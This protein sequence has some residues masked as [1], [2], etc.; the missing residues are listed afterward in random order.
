MLSVRYFALDSLLIICLSV[1]VV[2]SLSLPCSHL[3]DAFLDRYYPPPPPQ[4][5]SA[6]PDENGWHL[7][8]ESEHFTFY[9]QSGQRIPDWA[10]ELNE[11]T[12]AKVARL[13]PVT[14]VT[15]VKYY[16][17]RSQADLQRVF[18][19]PRKGYADQTDEGGAVHSVYSCHP[20]EVI[21]VLTYPIG[22]PPAL[23]EEGVA[24]AYDWR[25]AVEEGDVHAL[26]RG[27]LMRQKL[28]PLPSILTTRD[29]QV[30]DST[31]AYVVAGSFVKYLVDT[32]GPDKMRSLFT[33]PRYSDVQ[34]I[35]TA[36]QAIYGQSLSEMESEWQAFLRAWRPPERPSWEEKRSLLLFG[37]SSLILLLLGGI[38]F[39][40]VVDGVFG[41]LSAVIVGLREGK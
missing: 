37:G 2:V 19:R 22:R 18:G 33:V 9:T 30:H 27:K 41:R 38:A 29:F 16:K 11:I 13:L 17:Y 35:E 40:S 12:Y 26:A 25:F 15:K 23:F 31:A 1:I 10:V 24:V 20:H 34:E 3:I 8:R 5:A 32:Y 4:V 14:R 28:I 36:F 39:S 7:D 6:I 21:H